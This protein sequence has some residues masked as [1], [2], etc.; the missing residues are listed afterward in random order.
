MGPPNGSDGGDPEARAEGVRRLHEPE[1]FDRGR[2][3]PDVDES[4]SCGEARARPRAGA[5]RAG[6]ERDAWSRDD[7]HVAV[8]D[9]SGGGAVGEGAGGG[10]A[11]GGGYTK[12]DAV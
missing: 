7:D 11:G 3:R 5:D 2:A 9:G 12:T 1:W 4:L 6:S 8:G 10:A